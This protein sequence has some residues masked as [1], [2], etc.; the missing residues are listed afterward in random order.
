MSA[1]Q[2]PP[3]LDR[4]RR[5]GDESR[6][7]ILDHAVEVARVD[8]LEGLSFGRV[9]E[10]AGTPKSSVQVL[11][12][13]RET[14]QAQTLR[15]GAGLF[16]ERVRAALDAAADERPGPLRRLCE[17][18]FI[19]LEHEGCGTGCLVT[20]SSA[21][22]SARSGSLADLVL[23]L[24]HEWREALRLAAERAHEA[25]ELH[26]DAD[27]E[28]LVFEILALQSA[29]NAARARGDA[30]ELKRAREAVFF[31]LDLARRPPQGLAT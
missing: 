26:P 21:E 31:R 10:L 14:L 2:S 13:D 16:E 17:A 4:R 5:K 11:F 19:A 8:G 7:H 25:G 22:F 9:A 1:P 29:A 27:V 18:W 28:Q 24:R 12:R 3:T 15:H 6:R 20:S 23:A 30:I